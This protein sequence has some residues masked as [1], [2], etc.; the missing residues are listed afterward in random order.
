MSAQSSASACPSRRLASTPA[1]S[2]SWRG[3]LSIAA[4]ATAWGTG[5]AVAVILNRVAGLGPFA[6]TFWRF[7]IAVALLG[8]VRLITLAR[9]RRTPGS[10]LAVPT[11]G[12]A[13]T[14]P[15]GQTELVPSTAAPSTPAHSDPHPRA[16]ASRAARRSMNRHRTFSWR[17][18][19][20]SLVRW[21]AAGLTGAGLALYQSAYFASVDNVGVA[22]GTLVTLGGG[23]VLVAA[24]ARYFLGEGLTR[25][26]LLAIIVAT[27]GLAL[28]AAGPGNAGPHPLWGVGFALLSAAGYAA[29]TL[30]ARTGKGQ[31]ATLPVFAGGLVC[32]IPTVVTAR[33]L[34]PAGI[35]VPV[36]AALL[37]LGVVPTVLAY[38]WFF[39]GLTTVPATT[40][41]MIVLVEPITAAAIAVTLLHET[42]TVATAIGSGLL[43]LTVVVMA[44]PDRRR[45]EVAAVT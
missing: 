4:A 2:A 13:T 45:P 11:D 5:G 15:I 33:L 7:A 20:S 43:L 14:V 41:A 23:P 6:V 40:A 16:T 8:G 37:F 27:A 21:R 42:L 32:L 26:Q 24:G 35:A 10:P 28:L 38:R 44:H 36:G 31:G 18:V 25:R 3:A 9:R 39:Y 17:S 22:L 29:L 1:T 19:R 12:Q 34:P 30:Y